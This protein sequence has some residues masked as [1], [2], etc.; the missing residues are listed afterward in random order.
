MKRINLI[1]KQRR[2]AS[3][4]RSRLRGW[5]Y[6]CG[7]YGGAIVLVFVLLRFWR[8]DSAMFAGEISRL[9]QSAND[10]QQAIN[11]LTPNIQEKQALLEAARAVADQPDWSVLLMLLGK[12]VGDDVTLNN[13]QVE[14]IIEKPP[15]PRGPLPPAVIAAQRAAAAKAPPANHSYVIRLGGAATSSRGVSQFVVRLE[16]SGLF[17]SVQL[18]KS[19]RSIAGDGSTHFRVE[20]T[21]GQGRGS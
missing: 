3:R 15:A 8:D 2:D 14:P 21:I 18:I 7:V 6:A 12:T 1:P 16:Q 10:T 13:C 17:D 11:T 4:M 5:M 19:D 20:C 9:A